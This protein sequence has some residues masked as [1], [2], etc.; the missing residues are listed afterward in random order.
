[1]GG[2]M[3]LFVHLT[4][5]KHAR[6]IMRAGLTTSGV[7]CFP[8]LPSYTL[9]HQWLREL[10]RGGQ[11]A[12]VAV[13]FRIPDHEP[14]EVGRFARE[15]QT[16]S[17]AEAVAIIR[18]QEDP[19]GH[20]VYIPRPIARAEL[21]RVRPVSQ[22]AGWRYRPDEHGKRPCACPVCLPPGTYGAGDIRAR[23]S[24]DEPMPTYPELLKRLRNL[25]DPDG[26]VESLWHLGWRPKGQ[27]EDLVHLMDHPDADVREAL[28]HTLGSYRGRLARVLLTKLGADP[29][30]AVREA[31]AELHDPGS[32][33]PTGS[34]TLPDANGPLGS[35]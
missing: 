3:S 21:R 31:V 16:V 18:S 11:R 17:A 20:E 6:R 9:T 29:D 23:Y 2:I 5:E 1:L 27:V 4:P 12:F 25:A 8:S 30:L 26:I 19:R 24:H 13:D 7:Y 22:V 15:R 10:R 32:A 33:E 14:V 34:S 35:R 28:A